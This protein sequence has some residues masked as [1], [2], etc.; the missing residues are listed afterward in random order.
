[1]QKTQGIE[2]RMRNLPESLQK[3]G[4]RS[5]GGTRSFGVPAHA[6]D[7]REKNRLIGSGHRHPV[8]ILVAMSD[9]AYV[10]GLDLQ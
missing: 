8:L 7:H 2:N 5:L 9:Q 1:M 4:E 3:S 10:R 6:V